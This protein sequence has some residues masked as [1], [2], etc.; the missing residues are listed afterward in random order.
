MGPR[1]GGETK[2]WPLARRVGLVASG[3][4][5]VAIAIVGYFSDRDGGAT[6]ALLLS[7]MGLAVL[8]LIGHLVEQ[9][10]AGGV[11]VRMAAQAV[12]KAQ[13]LAKIAALPETT[14]EIR[15][16]LAATAIELVDP[17]PAGV[18]AVRR[19]QAFEDS[20]HLA[21]LAATASSGDEVVREPRS[22]DGRRRWDF[23]VSRGTARMAIEARA[24]VRRFEASA[25]AIAEGVAELRP[26]EWCTARR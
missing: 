16:E 13:T 15:N 17:V 1:L 4:I 22:R 12:D 19:E 6:V 8:G 5:L 25:V 23:V 10:S 11:E 21:I 18:R 14:P 26:A 9:V 20:A 3:A 24:N 2:S 7:G